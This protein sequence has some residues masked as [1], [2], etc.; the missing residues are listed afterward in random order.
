MKV[1]VSSLLP[2]VMYTVP[3]NMATRQK[4]E[5]FLLL[6]KEGGGTILMMNSVGLSRL[7]VGTEIK[8]C[9]G[10]ILG[11]GGG[12]KLMVTKSVSRFNI[13]NEAALWQ[14]I[15]TDL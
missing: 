4:K 2:R 1:P 3:F 10:L 7:F 13:T 6:L 15:K 9:C 5:A 11:V 8:S 14:A 12:W